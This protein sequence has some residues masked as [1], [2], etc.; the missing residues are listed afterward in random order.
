[1]DKFGG[2]AVQRTS[3]VESVDYGRTVAARR[4]GQFAVIP[5]GYADGYSRRHE[6]GSRVLIQGCSAPVVGREWTDNV[7]VDVTHITGVKISE[8]VVRNIGLGDDCVSLEEYVFCSQTIG[9]GVPTR[10]LSEIPG[11]VA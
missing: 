2:N 10:R 6:N 5:A 8:E 4:R 3:V 9:S 11:S 1:M 7:M